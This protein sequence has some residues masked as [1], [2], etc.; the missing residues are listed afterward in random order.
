MKCF[1]IIPAAGIGKRFGSSLPKQF[2]KMGGREIL[3][4]TLQK[5]ERIRN[6][7]CVNIATK[8]KYFRRIRNLLLKNNY[9]KP[10]KIIAG[11][12]ERQDSVFNALKNCDCSN[13]DIVLVHDAVRPFVSRKL[14]KE[15]ILS[16]VKFKAVIPV[17]NISDTIK[18][19]KEKDIVSTLPRENLKRAQTPQAFEYKLL[20]D[21]FVH[22]YKNNFKATD[23][24][25]ILENYGFPVKFIEGEESNI[26]ITKKSDLK[27]K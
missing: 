27:N 14:I 25:S 26:K 12:T 18:Q 7:S 13:N 2:Y 8:K 17:L 1:V 21:A 3:I 19:V 9:S 23:E 15:L 5:F 20:Y 10:F 22:A 24:S 16:A 6:V 4:H 11:G